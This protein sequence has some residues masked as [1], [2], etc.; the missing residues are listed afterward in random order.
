MTVNNSKY[1]IEERRRQV[2]LMLARSMTE[3]EIAQALNT[4]QST[5]STDVKALKEMS[6][7][8]IFDLDKSDL[9]FFYKQRLDSLDQVKREA[10]RLYDSSVTTTRESYSR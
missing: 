8:F 6:T 7:R 3:Q 10:W 1:A 9:S 4:S 5:I 2:S